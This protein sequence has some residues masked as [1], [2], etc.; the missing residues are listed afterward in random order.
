MREAIKSMKHT[1]HD[2]VL[3]ITFEFDEISFEIAKQM[4]K[5]VKKGQN[6]SNNTVLIDEES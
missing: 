5:I 4:A 3:D 2:V 6:K 1:D